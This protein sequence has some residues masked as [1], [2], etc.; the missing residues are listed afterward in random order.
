MGMFR[1]T[2]VQAAHEAARWASRRCEDVLDILGLPYRRFEFALK[3]RESC[4]YPLRTTPDKRTLYAE[5]SLGFS[6]DQA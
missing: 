3:D 1:K 6:E 5:L 4:E 2:A